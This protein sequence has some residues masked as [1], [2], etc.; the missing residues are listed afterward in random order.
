MS[1]NPVPE[2]FHTVSAYL[3]V[4]DAEAAI[5]FYCDA[6]GA[7]EVMRLSDAAG[8]ILHAE[9]QIGD[10]IVMLAPEKAEWGNRSPHTLGGSPVHL[11]VYVPDVDAVVARAAAAGATV[12]GAVA[13]Q[14]YGDRSGRI[15]DPAGHVWIVSTH[16]ED[17]SGEEMQR[18]LS[19]GV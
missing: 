11:H 14:F 2:G 12:L 4:G 15:V 13:D 18:R 9:I 19:T 6:F 10:S 5:A 16:R 8:G 7:T 3:N 17:V 1:V